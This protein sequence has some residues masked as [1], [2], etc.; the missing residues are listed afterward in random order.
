[1]LTGN[2]RF[3]DPAVRERMKKT[4]VAGVLDVAIEIAA[5]IPFVL[6][7]KYG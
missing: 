7:K 5:Q 4:W 1:V 2:L 3:S 6:P